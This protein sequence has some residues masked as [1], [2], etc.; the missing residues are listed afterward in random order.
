MSQLSDVLEQNA[1]LIASLPDNADRLADS[2]PYT[3][4]RAALARARQALV[5]TAYQWGDREA[6]AVLTASD[7]AT[8]DAAMKGDSATVTKGVPGM[9]DN[10]AV[11]AAKKY[12]A[13]HPG[14]SMADIFHAL[15]DQADEEAKAAGIAEGDPVARD[16]YS[17]AAAASVIKQLRK[18]AG[19]R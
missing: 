6:I 11:A 10:A 1:E 18:R 19:L 17:N 4:A 7:K 13:K 12:A 14:A 3:S 9:K 2:D 5:T 15:A 8:Y 16:G